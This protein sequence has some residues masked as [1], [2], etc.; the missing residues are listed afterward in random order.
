MR[1]SVNGLKAVVPILV[2]VTACGVSDGN[3]DANA[4]LGADVAVGT[5]AALDI[6]SDLD[7][8]RDSD[9]GPEILEDAGG[10]AS[11][12]FEMPDYAG[13]PIDYAEPI[14]MMTFN[15]RTPFADEGDRRWDN[16]KEAVVAQLEDYSPDILVVQEA[17]LVPQL[18]Y[19]KNEIPRLDW[20]GMDNS[21]TVYF[22]EYAAIFFD[23]TKFV[24]LDWKTFA[25]SDTP[26]VLPSQI[27]DEQKFPRAVTWGHF[28]RISDGFQFDI[29]STHWD[30]AEVDGI[31][32]EMARITIEQM[33]ILTEG[34]PALIGADF[35][36]GYDSLPYNIMVGKAE[37]NGV[38]GDLTDV[39]VELGLPEEGT[40][41]SWEG[42]AKP[43]SRIDWLLRNDG[44]VGVSADVLTSTY[45]GLMTSDHFP[46]VAEFAIRTP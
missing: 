18:D 19:L 33:D 42:V 43:T 13:V 20:V 35:N 9:S 40:Y 28:L 15:L 27:S 41:H 34:R 10:D 36:C 23:H 2:F 3:A 7:V 4:D 6:T 31:R 30:H 1:C 21:G 12:V 22:D 46:V 24:V 39:W 14:R 37:W 16:R 8:A 25:L 26:D 11:D 29:F 45:L 32:E 38:S 17:L 5:D 44:F